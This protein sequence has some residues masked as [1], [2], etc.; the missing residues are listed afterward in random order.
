MERAILDRFKKDQIRIDPKLF[1]SRPYRNI[2]ITAATY[3]TKVIEE[4]NA[5]DFP[6]ED[7][8]RNKQINF[9]KGYSDDFWSREQFRSN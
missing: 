4:G 7:A 6:Y 5:I 8:G 3:D 9:L 1:Q 2:R